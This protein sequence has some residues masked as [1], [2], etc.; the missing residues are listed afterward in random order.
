MAPTAR[1]RPPVTITTII[2]KPTM[3]SIAMVRPIA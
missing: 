2:E 3:M 1:L